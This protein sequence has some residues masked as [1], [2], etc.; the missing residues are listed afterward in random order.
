M[1]TAGAVQ[2]LPADPVQERIKALEDQLALLQ[3]E[4]VALKEST[5][6]GAQRMSNGLAAQTQLAQ[7][8]TQA[9]Q[10]AVALPNGRPS[11]ASADGRFTANLRAFLH[12]D[13]ADY[14]QAEPGPPGQDFRRGGGAGETAHARDLNSGT[15]LRR[16]RLGLEGKVFGDVDYAFIYEFGGSGAE[17]AGRVYEASVQYN[18][19]APWRVK[20]GN[21]V[22]LQGLEDLKN[23]NGTLFLERPTP[24]EI[25]RSLAGGDARTALQLFGYGDRWLVSGAVTGNLPGTISS[26]GSA[27]PQNFDEQLGLVGRVAFSPAKGDDWRIQV[28]ANLGYVARVADSGG[29]DVT[30]GRYLVE[31]RERPELR[32]D[33]TRLIDTGAIEARHADTEGLEFA[34][35]KSNFLIMTEAWRFGVQRRNSVLS[36]PRFHAFYIEGSW[37]MTGEARRYSAENAG[38][39]GPPVANPFNGKDK[40]GAWE[41]AFRYSDTDLNY[42]AGTLGSAPAADAIRGGEQQIWTAGL[43]WYWNPTVRFMFDLQDVKVQRLSPNAT[44]FSTPVGAEVGQHYQAVALRSQLAF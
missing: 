12:L 3:A 10:T 37:L 23:P 30:S 34:I 24:S 36:D 27:T 6:A 13:A 22:A 1:Q 5:S 41:L 9:A 25:T 19:F 11:L 43:N 39:D 29:P 14:R 20:V 18:R 21:F 26:T 33:G 8:Q 32:V 38:F 7:T 17:D 31:F 28:G 40:W 44:T 35:Q 42:H 4:I 16:A 15:N 2:A